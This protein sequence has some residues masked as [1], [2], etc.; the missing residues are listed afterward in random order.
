MI[1]KNIF[2]GL[3]VASLGLYAAGVLA[4]S[5]SPS[6]LEFHELILVKRNTQ[7]SPP[8]GCDRFSAEDPLKANLSCPPAIRA[9]MSDDQIQNLKDALQNQIP[10]MI[11]DYTHGRI[12]WHADVIVIDDPVVDATFLKTTVNDAGKTEAQFWLSPAQFAKEIKT[13]ANSK[14]Y[15]GIFAYA[16]DKDRLVGNLNHLDGIVTAP[17]SSTRGIAFANLSFLDEGKFEINDL[18]TQIW[19]REWIHQ[20]DFHYRGDSRVSIPQDAKYG[21]SD[22]AAFGYSSDEKSHLS[23]KYPFFSPARHWEDWLS[24]YLN[25]T[26]TYPDHSKSGTYGLVESAWALGTPSEHFAPSPITASPLPMPAPVPAPAHVPSLTPMPAPSVTPTPVTTTPAPE[27][28][29]VL[30]AP[31]SAR[32]GSAHSSTNAILN[33]LEQTLSIGAT[34]PDFSAQAKSVEQLVGDWFAHFPK[35]TRAVQALNETALLFDKMAGE[36]S[37][38]EAKHIRYRAKG[39]APGD[40]YFGR[41]KES[42]L[43]IRNALN[44]LGSKI[45]TST[46]NSSQYISGI[47]NEVEAFWSM[48]SMYPNDMALPRLAAHVSNLYQQIGSDDAQAKDRAFR[49]RYLLIYSCEKSPFVDSRSSRR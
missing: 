49:S 17:S 15:D 31:D 23:F 33:L 8:L 11:A 14:Y 21:V 24:A 5:H 25:G 39:P 35:D 37:A 3:A 20:L 22:A 47:D 45:S 1:Y 7:I 6:I 18:R 40:D 34:A 2:S 4:D 41:Y 13:Y 9:Q 28:A 42:F 38:S 30:Q 10:Q 36:D 29:C 43:G 48:Q 26:L 19:I 12:A 46:A 27:P 32:F 44:R 16:P